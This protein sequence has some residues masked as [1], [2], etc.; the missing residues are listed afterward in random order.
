MGNTKKG[1][2]HRA[3]NQNREPKTEEKNKRWGR[4]REDVTKSEKK[5]TI[6]LRRRFRREISTKRLCCRRS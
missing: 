4:G 5:R 3:E 6:I 2:W 1:F